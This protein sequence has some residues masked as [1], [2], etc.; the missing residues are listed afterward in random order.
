LPPDPPRPTLVIT[1]AAGFVGSALV[2]EAVLAG[3]LVVAVSRRPTAAALA[4]VTR[5]C[6]ED[7]AEMRGAPDSVLIH[8]AEP[9][10]LADAANAGDRHVAAMTATLAALLAQTWR[11]VVYASSIIV[12]GDRDMA[13]HRPAEVVRPLDPYGRAKHACE[14]AVLAADGT[15]LRLANIYGPGLSRSTILADLLA[16]LDTQGPLHVRNAGP[17]RDYLWVDDAAAGLLA[18]AARQAG[19]VF[20]LATGRDVSVRELAELV[21]TAAGQPGRPVESATKP[22]RSRISVDIADTVKEF[23]WQPRTSLEEGIRRL[24]SSHR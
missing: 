22:S 3:F 24:V 4:G 13:S 6:V 12:Y 8:L 2:R 11:H 14:A 15:V 5:M 21:L 18:A 17:E 9:P 16:Q 7:Y 1:G 10:G 20:N 23:G 19:G